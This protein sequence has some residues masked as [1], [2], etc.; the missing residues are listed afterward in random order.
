MD[1]VDFAL[2]RETRRIYDVTAMDWEP[3]SEGGVTERKFNLE[4]EAGIVQGFSGH[5]LSMSTRCRS[6]L[7]AMAAVVTS[8][9]TDN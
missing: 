4:R 9:R 8:A 3:I 6:Y 2:W 1:G 7:W 5:L